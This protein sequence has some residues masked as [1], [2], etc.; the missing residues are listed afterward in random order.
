MKKILL[1]IIVVWVNSVNAQIYFANLDGIA[2]DSTTQF[3][4]GDGLNRAKKVT[5]PVLKSFLGLRVYPT[6]VT[7]VQASN[8]PQIL[9][10][11][12]IQTVD[13]LT[14][15]VDWNGESVLLGSFKMGGSITNYV[16]ITTAQTITGKKIFADTASFE[17]GLKSNGTINTKGLDTE[18]SATKAAITYKGVQSEKDTIVSTDFD[19]D[20]RYGAVGFDCTTGTK[21]GKMPPESQTINWFFV[22]R[23]DTDDANEV[24]LKTNAGVVFYTLKSKMT[25]VVKNKNGIWKRER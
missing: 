3:L 15:L 10:N 20:G 18:G 25:I 1:F 24:V 13:S 16:T 4:V 2:P 12:V 9:R 19:F 21:S 23:K 7:M 6:K 17:K 11:K 14:Y 22:V 8:N 5:Y